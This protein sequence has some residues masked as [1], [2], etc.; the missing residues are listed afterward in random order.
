ML[1]DTIESLKKENAALKLE[2]QQLKEKDHQDSFRTI[3]EYSRLA[4]KVIS[5]DFKI[6]EV[7]MALIILLGYD[8]KEEIL[9]KGI[10]PENLGNLFDRY[11]RLAKDNNRAS[12]L[13]LGLYISAEIIR[14]HGGEMGVE[15]ELGKGTTF[16]F[17]IPDVHATVGLN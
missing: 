6:L 2:T 14:L 8:T 15:S 11:F 7:N 3:F 1:M 13:G 4:N 5:P 12:G 9:G 16:W 17:N 10:E